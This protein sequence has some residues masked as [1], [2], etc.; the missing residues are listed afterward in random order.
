VASYTGTEEAGIGRFFKKLPKLSNTVWLI[1]ICALFIIAAVPLTITLISEIS[2]QASLKAQLAQLQLQQERMQKS[3]AAQ[4]TLK[5]DITRVKTELDAARL[6]YKK[7]QDNPEISNILIT[8]AQKYDITVI[9]MTAKQSSVSIAGS[10]HPALTYQ[11]QLKGQVAGFQNFIIAVASKL[12]GSFINSFNI[13]P[14]PVEG[15]LD[16]AYITMQVLLQ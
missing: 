3:I 8:L 14:A 4:G 2:R 10:D 6:A 13:L 12:P 5:I 16:G 7:P 9:A 1:I 11:L 15:E